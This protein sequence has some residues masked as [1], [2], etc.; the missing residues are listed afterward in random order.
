[1]PYSEIISTGFRTLW[2]QKPLWLF[3]LLGTLLPALAAGIYLG[4]IF[5]WQQSFTRHLLALTTTQQLDYLTVMRILTLGLRGLAGVWSVLACVS[6]IGYAVN[7]VMRAATASEAAR[8]LAG[9]NSQSERGLTA[10]VRR[11][12][13]FFVIDLLWW[14][15]AVIV[16]ICGVGFAIAAVAGL[17]R[18]ANVQD[19]GAIAADIL[20]VVGV[21][22]GSIACLGV[23]WLLY[24]IARSLLAPLMYQAAAQESF[25]VGQ[26]VREGARLARAHIGPMLVILIFLTG[27]GLVLSFT[28]QLFTTPF[29][30]V[31]A[32]NWAGMV[33]DLSNGIPPAP[34]SALGRTAFYGLGLLFGLATW[35]SSA[36]AQTFGLTLYAEVYR[37]LRPAPQTDEAN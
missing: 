13:S 37:R 3:G 20:G 34:P 29:S 19:S 21:F 14:L 15:P 9:E 35:L 22:F 17:A 27:L 5:V 10:G 26:A 33:E 31:W 12:F 28:L 36:F 24:I 30:G 11:A 8:A 2:R 25:G 18:S 32:M 7:L 16:S 1:M 4:S 6:L 23:L